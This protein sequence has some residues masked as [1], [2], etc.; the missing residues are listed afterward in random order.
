MSKQPSA[1]LPAKHDQM[2]IVVEVLKGIPLEWPDDYDIAWNGRGFSI[3]LKNHQAT[4]LKPI[5][6]ERYWQLIKPR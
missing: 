6:I 4:N 1:K 2:D 5:T 3:S